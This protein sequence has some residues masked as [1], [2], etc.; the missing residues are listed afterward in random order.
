MNMNEYNTVKNL[1]YRAY[2]DYLK[3]KY[4]AVPAAFMSAKGTKNRRIT[5]TSDGLV[6]HHIFEDHAPKLADPNEAKK[7]PMEWQAAENLVYCDSLEHLL[8]HILIAEAADLDSTD[9]IPVGVGGILQFMVPELNDLYSG[10]ETEQDWRK[11]CHAKIIEDKDVYMSLLARFKHNEALY[12]FN[13]EKMLC[14]SYNDQYGKWS[15]S[16]NQFLYHEIQ[17]L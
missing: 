2:C 5:R 11:N 3:E 15:D 6:V 14:H 13:H 7:H 16:K 10:W 17:A 8:L 1:N 12:P 9:G 4:G